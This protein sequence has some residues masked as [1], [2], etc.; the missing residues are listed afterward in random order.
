MRNLTRA[1]C[2]TVAGGDLNDLGYAGVMTLT[3]MAIS[4]TPLVFGVGAVALLVYAWC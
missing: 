4:P 3:L 1:E 2:Q